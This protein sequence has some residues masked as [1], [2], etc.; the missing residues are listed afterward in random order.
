M[1]AWMWSTLALAAAVA[2]CG[3]GDDP[4]AA[5]A[6][7]R[8]IAAAPLLDDDGQAMPADPAAVPVDAAAR[9]QASRYASAPQADALAAALRGDVIRVELEG[10]GDMAADLAVMT[11]YGMQ[12]VRD[13]PDSTPVLVRGADLAQAA[14]VADRLAAGGY[15]NVCLV[16]L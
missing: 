2:G 9:T 1:K 11:A 15:P 12:A 16:T 13:L 8:R 4:S 10:E 3:G 6:H 7:E 5:L 14:R